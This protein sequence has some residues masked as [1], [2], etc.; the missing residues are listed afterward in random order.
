MGSKQDDI[1]HYKWLIANQAAYVNSLPDGRKRER[2]AKKLAGLYD[3][4]RKVQA[5]E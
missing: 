5:N 3:D 1:A 2:E 4:M